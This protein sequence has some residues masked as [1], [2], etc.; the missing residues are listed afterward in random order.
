MGWVCVW[1]KEEE[2]RDE[3]EEGEEEGEERRWR[4]GGERDRLTIRNW[5]R[6][7]GE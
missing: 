6:Q 1:E 5:Q 4:R 7:A 2:E 3:K